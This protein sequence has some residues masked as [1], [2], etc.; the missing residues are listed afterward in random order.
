FDGKGE[1]TKETAMHTQ[2]APLM[3]IDGLPE[4]QGATAERWLAS[5]AKLVADFSNEVNGDDEH[6][7]GID[8]MALHIAAVSIWLTSRGRPCWSKLDVESWYRL[9][10]SLPIFEPLGSNIVMS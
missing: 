3:F 6:A 1:G 5:T 2:Q 10:S 8:A 4:I 7:L 9:A